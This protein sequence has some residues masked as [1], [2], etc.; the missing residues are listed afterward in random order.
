MKFKKQ[1]RQTSVLE[2]GSGGQGISPFLSLL[3]GD[4]NVFL[5]DIRRDA[6]K[7]LR[8]GNRVVAD[9]CRLP[10]KDKTFDVVISVDT[11]EHI[12]QMMRH[13][14]YEELKRT[15]KEKIILTC[16]IQ[17][18]NGLFQGMQYDVMFQHLHERIY[19]AKEP[20]TEQHIAA[21]HPTLEEI[22]SELPNSSIY[23]YKNCD[24]WLKYMLFSRKPFLG[25]FCGLLYYL[26]WKRNDDKPPYW[27]AIIVWNR[28]G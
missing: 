20:N 26:F 7:G 27:G 16:P 1:E 12:P 19:R 11:V 13:N 28:T 22:N 23:A 2:V 25:L 5:L 14:L 15:C 18:N 3:R 8:N 21:G 10:F 17:S 24:I 9:R 6:F 4:C